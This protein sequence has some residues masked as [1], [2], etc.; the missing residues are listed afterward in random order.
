MSIKLPQFTVTSKQFI[1]NNLG[2]KFELRLNDNKL[3]IMKYDGDNI[4]GGELVLD[5]LPD[6]I[7]F[8]SGGE[9][10]NEALDAGITFTGLDAATFISDEQA[11]FVS[12]MDE[13]SGGTTII[14]NVN[15]GSAIVDFTIFF[16]SAKSTA[17]IDTLAM[18]LT[19]ATQITNLFAGKSA[20]LQ[21][22]AQTAGVVPSRSAKKAPPAVVSMSGQTNAGVSSLVINTVGKFNQL[23]YKIG[24]GA[25][26]LLAVGASNSPV[27]T[28]P[29]N[30]FTV[31]VKLL[32]PEGTLL[33]TELSRVIT[34]AVFGA[35]VVLM[36]N[37]DSSYYDEKV[38]GEYVDHFSEKVWGI[39][40][41]DGYL[42]VCN[43]D[44]YRKA[45]VLK[46]QPGDTQ[47][48]I[49]KVMDQVTGLS[50][51]N[52][53]IWVNGQWGDSSSNRGLREYT[54]EGVLVSDLFTGQQSGRKAWTPGGV[55]FW[56][57]SLGRESYYY[58]SGGSG[59][60]GYAFRRYMPSTGFYN[61]PDSQSAY[62]LS[63]GEAPHLETVATG[64]VKVDADGLYFYGGGTF[65]GI[66][67]RP[68]PPARPDPPNDTGFVGWEGFWEIPNEPWTILISPQ[69]SSVDFVMDFH[70]DPDGNWY[71]FH[72][73]G[74]V[75]WNS[76]LGGNMWDNLE[77]L[78][79]NVNGTD[80]DSLSHPRQF[81]KVGNTFYIADTNNKRVVKWMF[82]S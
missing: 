27:I 73:N 21:T 8:G 32:S 44:E 28:P 72:D 16:D 65:G 50:V 49:W 51:R 58:G 9:S 19:D 53:N 74:L 79:P 2:E 71:F 69:V 64:N 43:S 18:S 10:T 7:L 1:T 55:S 36:D 56:T 22:A 75:K 35:G 12:T 11:D 82:P 24:E 26:V 54:P 78:I 40:Y 38:E 81:V 41:L 61:L 80:S 42:Y 29:S 66:A 46:F 5:A 17:D 70:K 33:G 4:E 30:N 31:Y 57:D 59:G 48:L 23:T 6:E 25:W 76:N 14:N 77:Y 67:Y 13:T 47:M 62:K 45:H 15:E 60:R 20:A 39:I 34:M 63:R 68:H 3:Y 37:G 52:G